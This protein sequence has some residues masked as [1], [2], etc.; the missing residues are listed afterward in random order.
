MVE[1]SAK[2]KLESIR[3][4]EF[5]FKKGNWSDSDV[6]RGISIIENNGLEIPTLKNLA[7]N[8]NSGTACRIGITGAPGIGKST[9]IN[10]FLSQIN[11]SNYKVAVLAVDPSSRLTHGALL[12]DR[13][14]I[15]N[16]LVTEKIFFR[17]IASRGAYGGLNKSIGEILYFLECCGFNLILVETVGVGQNEVDIAKFTT[18]VIYV[19]DSNTGDEVQLEKA[20]IMEVA[21]IFFVNFREELVNQQFIHYL[22][23]LALEKKSKVVVGSALVGEGLE[24][25]AN[26]LNLSV[27][28]QFKS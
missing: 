23:L 11:L 16:N 22:N 25:L 13:I 10:S 12:G 28:A 18:S 20:G 6:A 26:Y 8:L 15:S 19:L 3:I 24:V 21:D 27:N 5:I 4:L 1:F 2:S 9:F 7:G 17:S 14:R